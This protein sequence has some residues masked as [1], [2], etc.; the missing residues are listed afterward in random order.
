MSFN[1]QRLNK[2][3]TSASDLAA[4]NQ[5]VDIYRRA[6]DAIKP[7]LTDIAVGDWAAIVGDLQGFENFLSQIFDPLRASLVAGGIQ[8]QTP[9]SRALNV[10]MR[11]DITD[12]RAIAYA[13]DRVGQ[14]IVQ[15]TEEIKQTVRDVVARAYR[16]GRTIDQI[17]AELR[18]SIGLHERWARAVDNYQR[19]QFEQ[20]VKKMPYDTA[21][22]RAAALAEKYRA[23][24]IRKR[25]MTIARTETGQASM[26]GRYLS[27]LQA[28]DSDLVDPYTTGKRWLATRPCDRCKKLNGETVGMLEPFSNG[29]LMPLDHP[30][31]KCRAVLIPNWKAS[32]RP[33]VVQKAYK[34]KYATREEAARAAANARWG[35]RAD[36]IGTTPIGRASDSERPTPADIAKL[37]ETEL[38]F[39]ARLEAGEETVGDQWIDARR[40]VRNAEFWASL[41]V[42]AVPS[43]NEQS[44]AS[45][46][47]MIPGLMVEPRDATAKVVRGSKT[48]ERKNNQ[49]VDEFEVSINQDGVLWRGVSNEEYAQILSS[50]V[51]SS[52]RRG[53]IAPGQEGTNLANNAATARSYLPVGGEGRVIAIDASKVSKPFL[54]GGDD[55]VRTREPIPAEAILAVSEPFGKDKD[56]TEYWP[57]PDAITKAYKRKFATREEAARFAA[58]ARWGNR[59]K[60]DTPAASI[61]T[62]T[63]LPSVENVTRELESRFPHLTVNFGI[64]SKWEMD[65][66]VANDAAAGFVGM[67]DLYPEV[68]AKIERLETTT[69][70]D[71]FGS[72]ME[73]GAFVPSVIRITARYDKANFDLMKEN[74]VKTGW[75][76][77]DSVDLNRNLNGRPISGAVSTMTH[78]FGH[79]VDYYLRAKAGA[80]VHDKAVQSAKMALKK[81]HAQAGG[82]KKTIKGVVAKDLSIYATTNNRELFA[83]AF[84][85]YYL[86]SNPRPAAKTIVEATFKNA[87]MTPAVQSDAIAKAYKRKFATREEAARFAANARWG[88]KKADAIG[89]TKTAAQW[90]D[91]STTAA[92]QQE[93]ESRFPN[94]TV[95]LAGLLPDV[96]NE[97]AAGFVENAAL[98]PEVVA[99]IGT[100]QASY[101]S[102]M[103]SARR[104]VLDRSTGQYKGGI[105]RI[106]SAYSLDQF[107][108]MS[109]RGQKS[110][111]FAADT[112]DPTRIV[113]GRPMTAVRSIMTH[114]FGHQVDYYLR[115][116]TDMTNS[117]ES[118]HRRAPTGAVDHDKFVQ[119]QKLKLRNNYNKE[120]GS[121]SKVGVKE[122]IGKSI[123]R[124]ATKNNLELFA[125]SFNEYYSSPNPRPAAK[126]IIE[127][128][129]ANMGLPVPSASIEKAYKRKYGS[130]SEAGRA[131]A[132]ARW[133]NRA[134]ETTAAQD[135]SYRMSHQPSEVGPR[136]HNLTEDG[137]EG[138]Y[139]TD[140]VYANPER[141]SGA[142]T[143]VIRE[144]MA[145]L[146]QAKG[147]PDAIVTIHRWAPEGNAIEAGNWVS[148]SKTYA[149]QHGESNSS[150]KAG[151]VISLDVPAKTIRFAGD[152]LAEFGYWPSSADAI[153][154]AYKRKYGSRSEAGR[155]AANARW[156]NRASQTEVAD[157][158]AVKIEP[159]VEQQSV[160]DINKAFNKRWGERTILDLTGADIDAAN[161]IADGLNELLTLYPDTELH[162]V[163]TEDVFKD[164]FSG[165][166]VSLPPSLSQERKNEL[167]E[168]GRQFGIPPMGANVAGSYVTTVQGI[169]IN[170]KLIAP[171]GESLRF[172]LLTAQSE[173]NHFYS[174]TGFTGGGKVATEVKEAAKRTLVHEFAHAID[175]TGSQ[176]FRRRPVSKRIGVLGDPVSRAMAGTPITSESRKKFIGY[177]V[178]EYASTNSA[179]LFAEVFTEYHLNP[180]PRKLSVDQAQHVMKRANK[181]LAQ[182]SMS[183]GIEKAYQRK[184]GSR[185]EAGR[186]AARARWGNRAKVEDTA[187]GSGSVDRWIPSEKLL[188]AIDRA[189]AKDTSDLSEVAP[190]AFD[191]FAETPEG[192]ELIAQYAEKVFPDEDFPE[193]VGRYALSKLYDAHKF[194]A[195]ERA[196]YPERIESNEKKLKEILAT[197][198]VVVN[199]TSQDFAKVIK[200]GRFKTQH[201]TGDSGGTYGPEMRNEAEAVMFGYN[202]R[203][204]PPQKRP[205]YGSIPPSGPATG[206]GSEGSAT[207]L[208]GDVRVVLN[209]AVKDRTTFTTNDSFA[210]AFAV[211]PVKN[212]NMRGTSMRFDQPYGSYI[213]AQ[214]HGGVQLSDIKEIVMRDMSGGTNI[215]LKAPRNTDA[216]KLGKRL[217]IPVRVVSLDGTVTTLGESA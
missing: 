49:E 84:A 119:S 125:E 164:A 137:G 88:G 183:N 151:S 153:A 67:A 46:V 194:H 2:A 36:A 57:A 4:I 202:T 42:G 205:I 91:L 20:L 10:T 188:D 22:E 206:P 31:C 133:G 216:A 40:A 209:D 30:N 163:G 122:V 74:N 215:G 111:F 106:S 107:Q 134:T 53:T 41:P 145:Q 59:T 199:I 44:N 203:R 166:G 204:T 16:E 71:V 173:D 165:R 104:A 79:H 120:Q 5:I 69:V 11:F 7:D 75:S 169:R 86:S 113:N 187:T 212:P 138:E 61:R 200:D 121:G 95:R 105:I 110:G 112:S 62:W 45:L 176:A 99:R 174:K 177:Y 92:I 39:A 1:F 28:A 50:G 127:S 162:F 132:N 63:D 168:L 190:K 96:A 102:A 80:E 9:L 182:P 60:T 158:A 93:L 77:A 35:N 17:A 171:G 47:G 55:Y 135:D 201:E 54:I 150:G 197:Q 56:G 38:G 21:M 6:I 186:A 70:P 66:G 180:K 170:A 185:S 89:S 148:L 3:T 37:K 179:E 126:T 72:A 167:I 184:Y 13:Q 123:S 97:V 33:V 144:T 117:R 172:A 161:G 51:I 76:P 90:T 146:K 217:G 109:S 81:M 25:A 159:W 48:Y 213:E 192:K 193:R 19:R 129:F 160:K 214:I 195:A 157:T 68:A 64:G 103:G 12:P 181:T 130:R 32:N 101:M 189:V 29:K 140:D 34:R 78:E 85:E 52:D 149:E 208:Y 152:D 142:G 124:Y 8:Q 178:G 116:M 196:G 175:F 118:R 114:E 24:L 23:R 43:T 15:V 58:N 73:G 156:G 131:A 154:K 87:G 65:L 155:A 207:W 141:Y 191:D 26:Y 98:F 128:A 143:T 210:M 108:E 27:W 198:P 100:I 115:T 83:E 136:A 94:M 139:L 18:N 147:N 211:S 82:Q 14:L